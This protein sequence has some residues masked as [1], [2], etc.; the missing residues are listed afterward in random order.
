MPIIR[1]LEQREILRLHMG[2]RNV[3]NVRLEQY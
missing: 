3:K 1:D 2:T